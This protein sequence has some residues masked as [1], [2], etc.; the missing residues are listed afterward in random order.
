[1]RLYKTFFL[2]KGEYDISIA[3]QDGLGSNSNR[4]VFFFFFKCDFAVT[5]I[6]S[7]WQL[8]TTKKYILPQHIKLIFCTRNE[9]DL[10]FCVPK[11]G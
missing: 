7:F 1:M 10:Q 4:S 6:A 11:L 3:L 9:N 2:I 5:S 8:Q